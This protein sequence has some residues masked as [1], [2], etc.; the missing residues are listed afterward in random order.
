MVNEIP[1]AS[2]MPPVACGRF[3]WRIVPGT[4]QIGIGL[5]LV[6]SAVIGFVRVVSGCYVP[7]RGWIDGNGIPLS[8]TTG[9]A[10]IAPNL[11][12]L[13]VAFWYG[14]THS[15]AGYLWLK[16]RWMLGCAAT[17]VAFMILAGV[18]VFGV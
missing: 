13:Q 8:L 18:L 12:K 7:S 6:V 14:A 9:Y 16:G 2:S 5:P 11:L 17:A 4:L 1:D 10:E 15:I 3:R